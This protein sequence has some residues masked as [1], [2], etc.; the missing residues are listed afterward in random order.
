VLTLVNIHDLT[1]GH[2]HELKHCFSKLRNRRFAEQTSFWWEDHAAMTT[3]Y[4][5]SRDGASPEALEALFLLARKP[6]PQ[7]Q[8]SDHT[9]HTAT[10]TPWK[11]GFYGIEC[12]NESRGWH[13]HLHA[14]IDARRIDAAE[15]ARQ[16]ASVTN[17]YG[18][19]VKV[20]D[21]RRDDYLREVTKYA[22]KGSQLAKWP[23]NQVL[24][25]ILAFQGVRTFGV[26][27]S[28]YGKRTEFSA[29]LKSIRDKKPL[30]SCG[31]CNISYY[32]EAE[33]LARDLE[34]APTAKPRPP[35]PPPDLVLA[36]DD[37][38]FYGQH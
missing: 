20:T 7:W 21:C 28:L 38:Q 33:W 12:T 26:F 11:G 4:Q 14:L 23:P 29:W 6:I 3:F 17:G 31:G 19:I 37:C 13:L 22:V 18:R 1:Q 36:L 30:C 24:E 35:T 27:G 8:R 2:V 5:A 34:P 9:G 25:F 32:T 10:S 15:L 16:W